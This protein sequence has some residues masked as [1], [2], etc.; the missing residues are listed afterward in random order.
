MLY[1]THESPATVSIQLAL[2]DI[3]SAARPH[4]TSSCVWERRASES[5]GL[6]MASCRY[7][8]SRYDRHLQRMSSLRCLRL[9]QGWMV[10]S[11]CHLHAVG[12]VQ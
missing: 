7:S 6:A 1:L 3:V 8:N 4:A 12:I 2:G 5:L 11:W 10:T 9:V